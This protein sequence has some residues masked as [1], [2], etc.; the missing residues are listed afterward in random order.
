MAEYLLKN[1]DMRTSIMIAMVV[2]A[3]I[4]CFILYDLYIYTFQDG[5][6]LVQ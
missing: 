1:C 3:A 2:V 5:T 4:M 6:L